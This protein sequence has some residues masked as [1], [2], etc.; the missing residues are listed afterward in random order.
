MRLY[1][2]GRYDEAIQAFDE[3]IKLD[4]QNGGLWN[5][6]GLAL[7]ALGQTYEADEAFAKAKELGY[8]G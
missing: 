6:K 8:K 3:A 1:S 4:P 7:N 2:Q 5:N